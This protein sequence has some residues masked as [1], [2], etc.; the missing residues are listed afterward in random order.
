M[1]SV[2]YVNMWSY[3]SICQNINVEWMSMFDG[4][5]ENHNS[6]CVRACEEDAWKRKNIHAL[7][8]Q[9]E[10][11]GPSSEHDSV[12][13]TANRYVSQLGMHTSMWKGWLKKTKRNNKQYYC[14]CNRQCNR[15]PQAPTQ[16]E[17]KYPN[18][19]VGR[20][21]QF[22]TKWFLPWTQPASVCQIWND[23]V[24]ERIRWKWFSW[25]GDIS[26]VFIWC[27]PIADK[28]VVEASNTRLKQVPKFKSEY[29]GELQHVVISA[30]NSTCY[31]LYFNN[32]EEH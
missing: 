28:T 27:L 16:H 32:R 10:A 6:A 20:N 15:L 19:L 2:V 18:R 1:H 13:Q 25:Q 31:C 11:W 23:S 5:R 4:P 26:P 22:V 3:S 24:H 7:R 14:Q 12:S 9:R 8:R 29:R 17:N 30:L 21:R